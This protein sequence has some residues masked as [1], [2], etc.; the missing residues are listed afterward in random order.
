[1]SH[2]Y[3]F[4]I[5]F[6]FQNVVKKIYCALVLDPAQVN[7]ANPACLVLGILIFYN[8]YLKS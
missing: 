6:L 4:Y 2:L 3:V 7:L 1:M 8:I 5:L